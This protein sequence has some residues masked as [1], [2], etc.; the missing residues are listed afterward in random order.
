M[1]IDL[2]HTLQPDIPDWDGCCGLQQNSIH[3]GGICVQSLDTPSGIG[4]H[5]NAPRYFI[6]DGL[7][8]ADIALEQ[9]VAH[10]VVIDV[11][12]QMSANYFVTVADIHAFEQQCGDLPTKTL[13]FALTGWGN[14]GLSRSNIAM[15]MLGRGS[16]PIF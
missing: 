13:V 1:L 12:A 16:K 4:T 14:I 11:R 6:A 2:T 15:K 9:L 10:A 8:I 3:Y 5:M 7:S